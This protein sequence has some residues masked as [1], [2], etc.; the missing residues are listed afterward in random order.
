MLVL[1]MFL[2]Q[3]FRI[4]LIVTSEHEVKLKS[5]Y[6]ENLNQNI[7]NSSYSLAILINV[8]TSRWELIPLKLKRTGTYSI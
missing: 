2:I 7:W 8:N 6:N 3:S 4:R 5:N 1:I